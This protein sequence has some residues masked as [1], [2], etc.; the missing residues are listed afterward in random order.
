MIKFL[1][2]Y[3]SLADGRPKGDDLEL[4]VSLAQDPCTRRIDL[5]SY[6]ARS[7]SQV[8]PRVYYLV[9]LISE[10]DWEACE[11]IQE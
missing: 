7:N 10:V 11:A 4:R 5:A 2:T 8:Q 6:T 9:Q 3:V 1:A